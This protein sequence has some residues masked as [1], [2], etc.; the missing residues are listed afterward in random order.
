MIGKVQQLFKTIGDYV[1]M[2]PRYKMCETVQMRNINRVLSQ[3]Q[4]YYE[5]SSLSSSD[6]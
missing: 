1:D 6:S 3:Y 4:P 2:I 5:Y